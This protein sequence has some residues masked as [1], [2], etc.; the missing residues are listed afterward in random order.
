MSISEWIRG[1]AVAA[2]RAGYEEWHHPELLPQ[3]RAAWECKVA[4]VLA[5]MH[6]EFG[7]ER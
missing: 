4:V 3:L 1:M 7:H 6:E 2:K 5:Q